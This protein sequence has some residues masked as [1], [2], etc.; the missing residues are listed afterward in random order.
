MSQV[1]YGTITITD[2]TDIERVYPIYCKGNLTDAPSISGVTNWNNWKELISQAGGTGDYIWQRIVTKKVGIEITYNNASQ[3]CSDAVRLTGEAGVSP[4]PLTISSTQYAQTQNENDTPSYGNSM[5]SS[6][7]EGWWLWVKVN[8]SDGN[9]TITKI[10]QGQQGISVT[11]T[12]ELYYLKTNT[13]TV[14][15]ITETNQITATDRQNGWTSIVPTYIVNAEYWTCI[16]TSLSTGGP[17]WSTPV[18]NSALTDAN[19]NAQGAISIANGINQHFFSIPTDYST[20]VPAGSYITEI[21]VDTFKQ[22]PAQGNLLTRA[23]GIWIR[24]GADILASLQGTG[25]TFLVPTGYYKGRKSLE[26]IGGDT[27]VINL[28]DSQTN[29]IKASFGSSITLGQTN[30]SHTKIS[31]NGLLIYSGTETSD[32]NVA[33]FGIENNLP[34][35]RVGAPTANHMTIGSEGLIYKTKDDSDVL[36]NIIT[37]VSTEVVYGTSTSARTW[38][39]LHIEGSASLIEDD[40]LGDAV[41]DNVMDLSQLPEGWDVEIIAYRYHYDYAQIYYEDTEWARYPAVIK[42]TAPKINKLPSDSAY[43]IK[44]IDV[45]D[46]STQRS[47]DNMYG[48][49]QRVPYVANFNHDNHFYAYIGIN[50]YFAHDGGS[51]YFNNFFAPDAD[52][53]SNTDFIRFVDDYQIYQTNVLTPSTSPII[54]F[55]S[56]VSLNLLIQSTLSYTLRSW[57]PNI[58]FGTRT[59]NTGVGFTTTIGRELLN[60]HS[61]SLVI[62]HYNQSGGAFPFL[63]GNG[64]PNARSNAFAVDWQG[65]LFQNDEGSLVYIPRIYKGTTTPSS[66]FG[67]NGD[68]YFMYNT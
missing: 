14:P 9:S 45:L 30:N 56:T 39:D 3:Y 37:A 32:T 15:T 66:N 11:G 24:N 23:D 62:G 34:T 4:N 33:F 35:A 41:E 28:Y 16:E 52:N 40:Y 19:E 59:A 20:S 47:Y 38:G 50:G 43:D 31:N 18:K 49:M 10:K 63:I 48:A 58:T 67:N 53:N 65:N 25:L 7:N 36:R 61:D 22:S 13:T 57:D 55:D 2:T 26:I 5:P 60:A 68:V 54:F 51:S 44:L 6:I 27:P 29:V 46:S 42:I 17:V 21:N 8:Y 64:T 1:S 12:R